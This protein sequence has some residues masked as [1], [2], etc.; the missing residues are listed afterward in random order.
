MS[1][2]IMGAPEAKTKDGFEQHFGIN[3]LAHFALTTLVLPAMIASSDIAFNSRVVVVSS[4]A[5]RWTSFDFDD[6]NYTKD[7]Q[8]YMSYGRSKI[9]NI[10]MANYIDR[11]FGSKG[12]HALSLNPGGVWT[13]LQRYST[14]DKIDAWKADAETMKVMQTPEQGASTTIWAA[15]GKLWEGKGGKFLSGC[16]LADAD[17]GDLSTQTSDCY[18]PAAYDEDGEKKLWEL[19]EALTGLEVE[20]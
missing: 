20:V 5:H 17:K 7:Y 9:A 2:A 6:Y 10:W 8:P 12:V 4:S 13:G 16:A 14:Q 1:A 15:L 3:H 18:G 11:V 19:S